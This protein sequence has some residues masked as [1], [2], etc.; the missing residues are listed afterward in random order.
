VMLPCW[1]YGLNSIGL[2]DISKNIE[3]FMFGQNHFSPMGGSAQANAIYHWIAD[4]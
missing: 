3:I 4:T 2:A 1:Y